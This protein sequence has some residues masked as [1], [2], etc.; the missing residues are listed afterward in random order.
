MLQHLKVV[1]MLLFG[2]GLF[3]L[4]V[5]LLMGMIFFVL[6]GGLGA[7]GAAS[8]EEELVFVGVFY[9]AMGPVIALIS[10]AMSLPTLITGWGLLRA[11]PWSRLAGLLVC[12]LTCMSFPLGTVIGVYGLVTLLDREVADHLERGGV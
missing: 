4:G 10:G 7:V 1:A 6:G 3:Q 11:R 8:G 2:W 12:A 9:G 5:A